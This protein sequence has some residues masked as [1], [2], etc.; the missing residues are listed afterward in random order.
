MKETDTIVAKIT[1]EGRGAVGIIRL[2]GMR[3][4]EIGRKLFKPFPKSHRHLSNGSFCTEFFCDKGMCVTFGAPKSFTGEDVVEFHLH[5]GIAILDGAMRALLQAGARVADRGEFTKRAF[6]NGKMDLS[7]AEGLGDMIDASSGALVRGG[8]NNLIEGR[9]FRAVDRI[10]D[11]IVVLIAQIEASLDY[12][13]ENLEGQLD[14]Y[15]VILS[16]LAETERLLKASNASRNI[17]E[18][19]RIAIIGKTNVGKSSLINALLGYERAIVTDIAGTTR[20]VVGESITVKDM[21]F[22]FMDTAGLRETEDVIEKIGIKKSEAAIKESGALI[23]VTDSEPDI[24]EI[25][26]FQTVDKPFLIVYNKS[27]LRE[28]TSHFHFHGVK[29]INFKGVINTSTIT[30]EGVDE[31]KTTLYAMFKEGLVEVD[32]SALINARQEECLLRAGRSLSEAQSLIGVTMDIMS[33]TLT[34][35][36]NALSEITGRRASE[37]IVDKIFE[38]FCLGK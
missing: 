34:D 11:N 17:R 16:A 37:E 9:L 31:I 18:G 14:L 3:A 29:N 27:D 28:K 8:G 5:G 32:S 10:I 33:M 26:F 2:S 22:H 13:E 21:S 30:R 20:D 6:I 12:P 25:N 1:P 19:V 38:K 24:Q 35:A 23:Y 4:F 7:G 36:V 15:E